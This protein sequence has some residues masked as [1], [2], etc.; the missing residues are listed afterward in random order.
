MTGVLL[1]AEP[2]AKEWYS[3]GAFKYRYHEVLWIYRHYEELSQGY[4]PRKITGYIDNPYVTTRGQRVGAYFED[5][6]GIMAEFHRRLD[7]CGRDGVI[8]KCYKCLGWELEHIR[9]VA[10]VNQERLDEITERV[11]RYISGRRKGRTYREFCAHW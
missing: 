6:A 7:A 1:M 11:T 9:T 2:K 5:A 3:A 4:W 10:N 8:V